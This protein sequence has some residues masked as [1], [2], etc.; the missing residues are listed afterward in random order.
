M[1]PTTGGVV[2]TPKHLITAK[3]LHFQEITLGMLYL[4]VCVE[5]LWPSQPNGVM[6]SVVSYLTT[7]L[8]GRLSPLSV[9]QYRAHSMAR[10]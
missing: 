9:N 2:K 6:S 3:I 4:F 1:C 5:V 10:S 8:L 7:L